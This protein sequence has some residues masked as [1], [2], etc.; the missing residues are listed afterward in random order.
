MLL[1]TIALAALSP[2]LRSTS[3]Q[4]VRARPESTGW[5]LVQWLSL[6]PFAIA[7]TG[8]V[9]AGMLATMTSL[10]SPVAPSLGQLFTSHLDP[11]ARL[12]FPI[13]G[14]LAVGLMGAL[15]YARRVVLHPVS[16]TR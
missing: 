7:L 5:R 15:L 10:A 3:L 4:V 1:L 14:G 16:V 8:L 12:V 9:W 2:W 11:V 13:A 6:A